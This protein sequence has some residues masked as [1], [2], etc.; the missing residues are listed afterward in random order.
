MASQ[1]EEGSLTILQSALGLSSFDSAV[2]NVLILSIPV[3][4][5]FFG[6][7]QVGKNYKNDK[8]FEVLLKII[9]SSS[10][11]RRLEKAP[12]LVKQL[13]FENIHSLRKY[14]TSEIDF[15]FM[16]K[17]NLLTLNDLDELK[18][19]GLLV[20]N[21]HNY[22]IKKGKFIYFW[23]EN[24][25]ISSFILMLIFLTIAVVT[26]YL[27]EKF[28]PFI[29]MYIYFL[30][31]FIFIEFYLIFKLQAIKL[32]L[33]KKDAIETLIARSEVFKINKGNSNT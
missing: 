16:E 32:F 31:I 27:I 13:F 8:Q 19:G 24:F 11:L 9:D 1:T 17:F 5:S 14:N 23:I 10:F 30:I 18:K 33:E 4:L 2:L 29:W 12:I 25:K 26:L 7:M 28:T 20:F 22:M 3:L 6:F 21:D 15:L